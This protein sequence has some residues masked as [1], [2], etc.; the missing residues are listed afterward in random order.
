[1]TSECDRKGIVIT[2]CLSANMQT[3]LAQQSG[4]EAWEKCCIHIK[5]SCVLTP[6]SPRVKC[7]VSKGTEM[8]HIFENCPYPYVSS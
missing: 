8:Y 5:T 1:M 6:Q 4:A 3:D 7:F 2:I